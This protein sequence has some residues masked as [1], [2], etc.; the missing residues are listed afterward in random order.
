MEA[1]V[2]KYQ[3]RIRETHLDAYAHVNNATY[4]VLFEE[5]RWELITAGGFGLKHVIETGKGTTLLEISLRFKREI[6]L[7]ELITIETKM[8]YFRGKIGEIVQEMI[9]EEGQVCCVA[10]MKIGMF[11][12]KK[13]KLIP[14]TKEWLQ[15]VGYQAN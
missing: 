9:N 15:A 10:Q 7:R 8:T 5:A 6:G 4:L 3:I 1:K 14:P 13:R 12:L 11:D 2:H